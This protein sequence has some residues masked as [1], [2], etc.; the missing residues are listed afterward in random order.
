MSEYQIQEAAR[1]GKI[2]TVEGLL[3]ENPKLVFSQDQDGRTALHW[4][5]SSQHIEIVMCILKPRG[6]KEIDIDELVDLSGWTPLHIAASVGNE[7][8]FEL[9]MNHDPKP[10]IDFQTNQGTTVLHLACSKQRYDIAKLAIEKYKC[11]TRIKDKMGYTPLH[12]AASVGSV[13]IVELLLKS[14]VNVN[15]TDSEDWTALKH[16]EAEGWTEVVSVLKAHGAIE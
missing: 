16:A 1:D 2:L 11:K 9:L 14:G 15:A 6:G 5:T 3:T 8:I 7:K 13:R 12:R 4:A 10:D